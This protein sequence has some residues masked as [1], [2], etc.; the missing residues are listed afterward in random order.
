M[1]VGHYGL[2][3]TGSQVGGLGERGLSPVYR[4]LHPSW[5]CSSGTRI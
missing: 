4:G 5:Q 3:R 2:T 1:G